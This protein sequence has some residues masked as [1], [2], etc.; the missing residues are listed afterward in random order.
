MDDAQVIIDLGDAF[1][2]ICIA[3]SRNRNVDSCRCQ[4]GLSEQG[5]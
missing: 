2:E 3:A 5:K 4:S 1:I